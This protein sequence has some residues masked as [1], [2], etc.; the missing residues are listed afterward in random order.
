MKKLLLAFAA[1]LVVMGSF[2]QSSLSKNFD[3]H[4][5]HHHHG[6]HAHHSNGTHKNVS[7]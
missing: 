5:R 4:H 3:K 7:H 1:V 2:A 6:H